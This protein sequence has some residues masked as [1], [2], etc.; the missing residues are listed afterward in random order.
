MPPATIAAMSGRIIELEAVL[1]AR[2]S[3]ITDSLQ[4]LGKQPRPDQEGLLVVG[5]DKRGCGD[6]KPRVP[7]GSPCGFSSIQLAEYDI[8]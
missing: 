8:L 4:E 7:S 2:E 5:T 3:K 1:K 6:I